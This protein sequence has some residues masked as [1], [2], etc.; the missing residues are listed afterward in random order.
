MATNNERSKINNVQEEKN[1]NYEKERATNQRK[2]IRKN[3]A[4]RHHHHHHHQ[5]QEAPLCEVFVWHFNG[6]CFQASK[7]ILGSWPYWK[8]SHT[9]TQATEGEGGVDLSSW[10]GSKLTCWGE[11]IGV[12]EREGEKDRKRWEREGDGGIGS[13]RMKRDTNGE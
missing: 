2:Q 9:H 3:P 13:K 6:A 1:E 4:R 11:G 12:R 5:D 8:R 10:Q 7:V